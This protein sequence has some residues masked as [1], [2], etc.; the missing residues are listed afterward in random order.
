[1]PQNPNRGGLAARPVPPQPAPGLLDQILARFMPAQPPSTPVVD[2]MDA[3]IA[4]LQQEDP[5]F[6]P[7]QISYMGTM[8]KHL[9]P[10]AEAFTG[11]MGGVHV[12]RDMMTGKSPDEV[13]DT[14]LHEFTH[15]RQAKDRGVIG[16]LL[17][18][19]QMMREGLPYGQRPDE[20][21]AFQA[22]A[23]RRTRQGRAPA[24]GTPNFS[25]D[26]Q[27]TRGDIQLSRKYTR[28]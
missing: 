27:A 4:K 21:E 12:N 13:A 28:K 5:T 20:M 19:F 9:L 17:Q 2:N 11:P 14:L 1:M 10:G 3:G 8:G 22:E 23:D 25:D 6:D 15:A 18:Q 16:Q 24:L 7:S 26:G